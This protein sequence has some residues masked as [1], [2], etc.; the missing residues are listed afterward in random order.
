[1]GFYLF[2]IRLV[3]ANILFLCLGGEPEE[4]VEPVRMR[5]KG[6]SLASTFFCAVP[7]HSIQNYF[8]GFMKHT[9][10]FSLCVRR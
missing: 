4:P 6:V 3:A 1:M 10:L 2:E 8:L 5:F 7:V 9:L